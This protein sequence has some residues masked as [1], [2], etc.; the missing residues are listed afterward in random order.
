MAWENIE[1]RLKKPFKTK[2]SL[3]E[4]EVWFSDANIS[5]DEWLTSIAQTDEELKELNISRILFLRNRWPIE[6]LLEF[7]WQND[8]LSKRFLWAMHVRNRT[9]ILFFD[10]LDYRPIAAIEPRD[11]LPLYRVV[12]GK[13]LQNR[14]LIPRIPA[15]MNTRRADLLSDL[16]EA[17]RPVAK[18][19]RTPVKTQGYVES[20]MN[21][22]VDNWV[23]YPL[24]VLGFLHEES[25]A[26]DTEKK[27]KVA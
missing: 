17:W 15:S 19:I 8:E 6:K 23:Y 21:G 5:I 18:E 24:P 1:E 14:E 11:A 12:I 20:L 27:E 4:G 26:E 13:L 9:Y 7:R 10:G 25:E 22:W 3:S 16:F 2:E